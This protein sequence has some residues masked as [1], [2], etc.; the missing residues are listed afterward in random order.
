MRF[1]LKIICKVIVLILFF[2]YTPFFDG[3]RELIKN[4]HFLDLLVVKQATTTEE[5]SLKKQLNVFS[6]P[7]QATDDKVIEETISTANTPISVPQIDSQTNKK[8]IYIY[9]THQ[10]EEYMDGKTVLDGAKL[11]GELLKEHGYEV[12]V[13]TNSFSDYMKDHGLDYND[14]YLVSSNFLNDILVNYGPF[15]LIID[16]HRDAVPRESSYV[17]LNGTNYARM[18]FV[19]GN[20][21]GRSDETQAL[22]K[23]LYDNIEQIQPGIMKKTMIREAYYNQEMS[24]N[25][26]LIEVGSD[27][28]TFE[29]VESSVEVLASGINQYLS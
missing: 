3:L 7:S 16:F 27:H 24:D 4:S 11:L 25:M 20:L 26:I 22:A 1:H 29:E 13:E 14:S 5:F 6:I 21:S 10:S 17:N 28:N 15:D 23:S 9:D 2:L 8:K 18:M 19:V 12:I